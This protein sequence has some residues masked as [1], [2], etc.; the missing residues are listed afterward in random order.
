MLVSRVRIAMNVLAQLGLPL[1]V[2]AAGW[3]YY[4]Q[5]VFRSSA[6]SQVFAHWIA[7]II[8]VCLSVAAGAGMNR[9]CAGNGIRKQEDES[10]VGELTMLRTIF[11]NLPDTIYVKDVQSRFLLANQAAATNM[12]LRPAQIF[13]VKQ[14]SISFQ[15]SLP[16]YSLKTS[17]RFCFQVSRWLAGKNKLRSKTVKRDTFCPQRFRC[18]TRRAV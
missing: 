11:A 18:L 8:L 7:L 6:A 2:E 12:G 17:V 4:A 3:E 15:R 10:T 16:L 1:V 9:L 14:I 13:L 5:I